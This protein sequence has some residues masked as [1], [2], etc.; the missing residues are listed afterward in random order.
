MHSFSKYYLLFGSMLLLSACSGEPKPLIITY[1]MALQV[2]TL[3]LNQ[4]SRI[5]DKEIDSICRAN[6]EIYY[7]QAFD[8]LLNIELEKMENLL[9]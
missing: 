4:Y 6:R 1:K 9:Q 3:F 8:S 2:D 7:Q 5:I